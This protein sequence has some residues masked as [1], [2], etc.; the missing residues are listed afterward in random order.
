MNSEIAKPNRQVELLEKAAAFLTQCEDLG[1]VKE[2]WDQAKELELYAKQEDE[3]GTWS[4]GM[5]VR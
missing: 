1:E 5:Q 4:I 2:L 3:G